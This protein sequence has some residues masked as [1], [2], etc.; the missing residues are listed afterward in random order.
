MI[1]DLALT[2]VLYLGIPLLIRKFSKSVWTK[3][4]RRLV[5]FCNAAVVYLLFAVLYLT[6]GV[7]TA[8]NMTA[9]V[10]WSLLALYI[11][12]HWNPNMNDS[13]NVKLNPDVYDSEMNFKAKGK[14][15]RC[16]FIFYYF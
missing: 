2:I 7:D 1:L 13:Q 10:I 4:K 3:K 11:L 9:A 8:P 12:K 15:F 5:V 16:N 6:M 14:K